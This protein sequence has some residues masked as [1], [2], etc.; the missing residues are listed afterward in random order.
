MEE[1]TQR[2]QRFLTAEGAED[3]GG[4]FPPRGTRRGRRF[5]HG[6]GRAPAEKQELWERHP[7]AWRDCS[8]MRQASDPG[9]PQIAESP[10]AEPRSQFF[11]T[12]P[13]ATESFLKMV[14]SAMI[15]PFLIRTSSIVNLRFAPA[16]SGISRR[17]EILRVGRQ[18]LRVGHKRRKKHKPD[19]FVPVCAFCGQQ[20][21]S[22]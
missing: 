15:L 16:T 1:R 9:E 6:A 11:T 21:P 14:L 12:E 17:G 7:V 18:L 5:Y 8:S 2:V 20:N 19:S 4:E 13:L 3:R 10:T 22:R